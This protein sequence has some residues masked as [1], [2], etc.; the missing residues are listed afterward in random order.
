MRFQKLVFALISA[1][2]ILPTYGQTYEE[3]NQVYPISENN[4]QR[5]ITGF[6]EFPG[7]SDEQIYANALKWSI[8]EYCKEKRDGLTDVQAIKKNF[9]YGA[10]HDYVVE[11][12]TK[13]SFQYKV[14]IKVV[15]GKLVYTLYDVFY[16][17]NGFLPF[18]SSSHIDKLN[19][20][21]K[22]K[23]KD[24]IHAFEAVA[25]HKL[26]MLFD[27]I[28]ANECAPISHWNDINIQRPVKGM[29]ADEC[30]LALGKPGTNY[31]DNN[32]RIQWSYGL[33]LIL[34]FKGGKLES[35]IR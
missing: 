9:S 17:A 3:I 32:N 11:G 24:I 29:N 16:R 5:I 31:E 20:A 34:I 8:I 33:N 4:G 28:V 25:S 23:H 6:Q 15:D 13:Y 35:I 21:K 30:F 14:D 7:L 27:A 2:F 12:K 10:S 1:I 26:N 18:S 19:P 22:E